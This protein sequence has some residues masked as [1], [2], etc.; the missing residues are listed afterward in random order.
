MSEH[1]LK[2]DLNLGYDVK[3]TCYIDPLALFFRNC[4]VILS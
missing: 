1:I 2:I 3:Q 4:L